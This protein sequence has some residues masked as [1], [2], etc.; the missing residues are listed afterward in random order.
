MAI[1]LSPGKTRELAFAS[2]GCYV[3]SG[4][5]VRM[6]LLSMFG[7]FVYT[8]FPL[9]MPLAADHSSQASALGNSLARGLGP[10]VGTPRALLSSTP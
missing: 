9:L 4:G 8:G 1:I 2:V 7:F 3:N 10:R 6:A 5:V